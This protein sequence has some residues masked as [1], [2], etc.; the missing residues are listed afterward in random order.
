MNYGILIWGHQS[1]RIH[2][3]QKRA[4][5][6]ITGSKYNTHS[7][8]LFKRLNLLK[9]TDIFNLSQLKFFHKYINTQLPDYFQKISFIQRNE[10]HQHNTRDNHRLHVYVRKHIFADNCIRQSIP[11]LLNETALCIKQKLYTHSL[12]GFSSYTKNYVINAY[13]NECFVRHC[14]VCNQP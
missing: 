1:D 14:H 6:L 7:E 9:I 5:R 12:H 4:I 13:S 3:L 10:L 8:R 2:K 11:K